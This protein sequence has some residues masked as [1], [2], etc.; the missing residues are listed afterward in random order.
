M[1]RRQQGCS[2]LSS[3]LLYQEQSRHRPEILLGQPQLY[4]RQHR[5]LHRSNSNRRLHNHRS[6]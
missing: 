5:G 3:S 2:P 4:P 1:R 6:Q